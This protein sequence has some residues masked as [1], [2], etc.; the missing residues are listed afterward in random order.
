MTHLK[1]LKE[2]RLLPVKDGASKLHYENI[3]YMRTLEHCFHC[4]FCA[5]YILE[6]Q[7]KIAVNG[8][9]NVKASK[10]FV[11]GGDGKARR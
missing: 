2:T 3:S 11:R 7:S 9:K 6:C 4:N 1:G 10:E 5:S 8:I